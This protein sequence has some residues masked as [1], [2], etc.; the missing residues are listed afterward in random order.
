MCGRITQKSAPNQL[1]LKIIDLVEPGHDLASP[2]PCFNGAPGQQH[3][4][5]RRNPE[6]GEHRLDRLW[7]GL[8]PHWVKDEYGGRKPI[9]A[10]AETVSGLPS[11]S[12]GLRQAPLHR[13]GRQLLRVAKDQGSWSKAA[14]RRCHEGRLAVRPRG[15]MGEL[16]TAG[17]RGM[18][19][20]LRHHHHDGERAGERDPRQDAGDP[21]PDDYDRW[22][23]NVE[24]DPRDLLVPYPAP[25]MTMWPISTRVN[26]PA[27]DDPDLLTPVFAS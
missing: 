11:F 16:V 3:W 12:S 1:A 2:T 20:H 19:A 26:S 10:K 7:W 25:P 23:S 18:G 6:T 27:N 17:N 5:I 13:P 21:A 15:H 8:I 9:N 24:P 22:L 14:L 4:V